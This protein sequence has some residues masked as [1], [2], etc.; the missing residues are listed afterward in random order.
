MQHTENTDRIQN[1]L[2]GTRLTKETLEFAECFY[3]QVS[4]CQ[5]CNSS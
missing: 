4:W 2:A 3:F 1:K 5:T